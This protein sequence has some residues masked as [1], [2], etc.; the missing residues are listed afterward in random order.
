MRRRAGIAALL[1]ALLLG[2]CGQTTLPADPPPGFDASKPVQEE[3]PAL[4][5]DARQAVDAL[6]RTV[7][8]ERLVYRAENR[9]RVEYGV[10]LFEDGYA[11]SWRRVAF[12]KSGYHIDYVRVAAEAG[13]KL[14]GRDDALFLLEIEENL[15]SLGRDRSW[16]AVADTWISRQEA[17]ILD[18]ACGAEISKRQSTKHTREDKKKW[19]TVRLE[20]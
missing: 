2:G 10:I 6:G 19:R 13:E 12:Y 16:E 18:L 8:G 7:E 20:I 15:R 11:A 3:L 5:V 1:T 14:T 4:G 9:E 17:E